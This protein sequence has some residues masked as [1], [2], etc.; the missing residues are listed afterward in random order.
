MKKKKYCNI[1]LKRVLLNARHIKRLVATALDDA[2]CC[3]KTIDELSLLGHT[4]ALSWICK[5][6]DQKN[7]VGK[8]LPEVLKRKDLLWYELKKQEIAEIFTMLN[9]DHR[10]FFARFSTPSFINQRLVGFT[11]KNEFPDIELNHALLNS[12]LTVFYIE[13][14]G[15]G[16]GLGVLDVNKDNIANAYML[17]LNLISDYERSKI[18]SSFNKLISRDILS[19]DK[20]FNDPIRLDF[21]HQVLRSFGIDKY[22]DKIK[23]SLLDMHKSRS[24]SRD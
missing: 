10:I 17:N 16:R 14:I 5:F 11:H 21:E 4:G 3:S 12:I 9:P 13:A 18:I 8:P 20:E 23:S 6:K 1:Y 24:L 2:F 7:G 22:F 15:F 19:I